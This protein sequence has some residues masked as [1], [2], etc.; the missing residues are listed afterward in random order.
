MAG[1]L[2]LRFVSSFVCVRDLPFTGS[3]IALVGR[4][5]V[6]KSSLINALAQRKNLAR[7]SKTPGATRLLNAYELGAEGSL[8]WL[9]DMPGYGYAKAPKAEQSRWNA[10]AE[11]YLTHRESLKGVLHLIDAAVGPTKLDLR[12][13]SWLSGIGLP[14]SYVATKA[15]KVRPSRLN[16]R[17][18]EMLTKLET[19]CEKVAHHIPGG[20]Q[21]NRHDQQRQNGQHGRSSQYS[22]HAPGGH[23]SQ[24]GH[25]SN[26]YWV[27]AA[28]KTGISELRTHVAAL[29]ES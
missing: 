12:T 9:V 15:D 7:T 19:R 28:K 16:S 18:S 13:V 11:E 14:I 3:E 4:S 2:A 8:H 5:N 25:Q 1:V 21:Q 10:M 23:Q 27:S 26:I 17:R 20:G 22:Q 6:G 24:S 29:L